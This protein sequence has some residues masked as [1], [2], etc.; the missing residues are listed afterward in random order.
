MAFDAA[1]TRLE[2]ART[3]STSDREIA[4][5]DARL[6]LSAFERLGARPHADRA[7]ALLREL[8]AGSRP[9]PHIAGA[10]TRRENE[11]LELL[12]HGLSNTEIGGRLFISPKT[13]EHH[14]GRILS[15]LGLRNRAEAVAWALRH[16][17][18]K[19]DDK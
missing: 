14:V 2:W 13:V 7:A 19:S 6:A 8:G 15:K 17:S 1:V 3:L 5:E 11:V 12:S 10:L 4:T 16:P 9:G 18:A